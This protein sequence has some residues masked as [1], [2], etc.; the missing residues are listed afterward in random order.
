MAWTEENIKKLKKLIKDKKSGREIADILGINRNAVAGKCHRLGLKLNSGLK[1]GPK[2]SR[3]VLKSDRAVLAQ[4]K[5]HT[6][7]WGWGLEFTE[8]V[9]FS[10]YPSATVLQAIKSLLCSKHI[11]RTKSFVADH[12]FFNDTS[13]R[14]A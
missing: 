3:P 7:S 5:K 4:I 11:N 9:E 1:M 10:E 14:Q 6:D 13:V 2:K 12:V 8:I